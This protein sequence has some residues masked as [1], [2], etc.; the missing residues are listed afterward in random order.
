MFTS[1]LG[2]RPAKPF[3]SQNLK[4]FHLDAKRGRASIGGIP[5]IAPT[6]GLGNQ[7]NPFG[8]GAMLAGAQAA[9]NLVNNII[10]NQLKMDIQN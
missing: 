1:L 8:P 7:I 2:S 3:T 4:K 10:L 9:P 5:H 6:G